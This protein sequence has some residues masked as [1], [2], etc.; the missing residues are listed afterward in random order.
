L[1]PGKCGVTGCPLCA[2]GG[3]DATLARI[4]ALPRRGG[5]KEHVVVESEG[6]CWVKRLVRVRGGWIGI[7]NS[8]WGRAAG[9]CFD[10]RMEGDRRALRDSVG[11][12][13]PPC[14]S[15]LEFRPSCAC[16]T[17][18][19]SRT[20][21]PVSC[22]PTSHH[23]HHHHRQPHRTPTPSGDLG[24]KRPAS[25]PLTIHVESPPNQPPVSCQAAGT[26]EPARCFNAALPSAFS[27]G[28]ASC[29]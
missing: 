22:L 4:L 28:L 6:G 3:S 23:H 26:A 9:G 18:T 8:R 17:S 27:S 14:L 15:F 24:T 19:F 10:G 29:R 5:A 2:G 25:P 21:V 20:Q 1:D 16:N 7:H 11:A 13:P 12:L